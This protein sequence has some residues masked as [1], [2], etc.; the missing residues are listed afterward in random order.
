[1][2]EDESLVVY[3]NPVHDYL[4]LVSDREFEFALFDLNGKLIQEG[5]TKNKQIDFS[6]V[7]KGVY[8]L[9]LNKEYVKKIIKN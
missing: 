9:V 7:N 1:M 3:P 5:K 6:F 4:N 2:S 8:L